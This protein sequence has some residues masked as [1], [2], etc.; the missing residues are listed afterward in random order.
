MIRPVCTSCT[1]I[2]LNVCRAPPRAHGQ[3]PWETL[4]D[5]Q[6]PAWV[7]QSPPEVCIPALQ[8]EMTLLGP[9]VAPLALRCP[10]IS[11]RRLL[12]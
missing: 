5:L 11:I 6:L 4:E 12:T 2:T 7:R 3:E 8:V 10:A 1:S 9:T